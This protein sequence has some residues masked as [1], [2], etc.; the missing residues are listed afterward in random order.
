MVKQRDYEGSNRSGN[1]SAPRG[2]ASE[3]NSNHARLQAE[4]NAKDEFVKRQQEMTAKYAGTE[5][6]LQPKDMM[7]NANMT[8]N[9]EHAK[10]F[11]RELTRGLDKTAFPV[12]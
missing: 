6:R 9:G 4:H 1:N 7:M 10:E 2:N 12:K 8:N 3:S 11:G 5:P